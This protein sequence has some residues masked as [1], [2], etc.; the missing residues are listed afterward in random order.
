MGCFAM[1]QHFS[2]ENYR[3]APVIMSAPLTIHDL[4]STNSKLNLKWLTCTVLNSPNL[5]EPCITVSVNHTEGMS[6]VSFEG[7]HGLTEIA[8]TQLVP[9]LELPKF[10]PF[11]ALAIHLEA[12]NN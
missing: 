6:L 1:P 8:N 7:G 2:Q 11:E 3:K 12:A 9:V 10:N 5:T 4:L